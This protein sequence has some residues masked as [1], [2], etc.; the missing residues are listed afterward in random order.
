VQPKT[1]Y[2][3]RILVKN[4]NIFRNRSLIYKTKAVKNVENKNNIGYS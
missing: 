3:K 4:K 1:L 2:I